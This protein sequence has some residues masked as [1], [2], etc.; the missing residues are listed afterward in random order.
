[1]Q[2]NF[3]MLARRLFR[4]QGRALSKI[5]E[6]CLV[7]CGF[8]SLWQIIYPS[9]VFAYID[10]NTGG[11]VFQILFPIISA[12]TAVLLFFKNQAVSVIKRVIALVKKMLG[13]P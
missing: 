8:I 5:C 3:K 12:I 4:R 6:D 1:M 7:M 13:R 9:T 10:P 11:Y 2:N